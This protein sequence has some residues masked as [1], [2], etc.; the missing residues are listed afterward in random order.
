M[1]AVSE[2]ADSCGIASIQTATLNPMNVQH[3]QK[4]KLGQESTLTFWLQLEP[5]ER[6]FWMLQLVKLLQDKESELSACVRW[7]GEKC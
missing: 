7:G 4:V 2:V 6:G 5:A 1:Q 3:E